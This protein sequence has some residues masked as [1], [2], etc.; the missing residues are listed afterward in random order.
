MSHLCLHF[1]HFCWVLDELRHCPFHRLVDCV[2]ACREHLVAMV[3]AAAA[4]VGHGEQ[5]VHEVT[6]LVV[7]VVP[8]ALLVVT[9]HHLENL[10]ELGRRPLRPRVEPRRPVHPPEPREHVA[11]CDRPQQVGELPHRLAD[12]RRLDAAELL[13]E[14]RPRHDGVGQ[15]DDELSQVDDASASAARRADPVHERRDLLLPEGAERVDPP[16]AEE[17]HDGDAAEAA[18][19]L[20][21]GAERDVPAAVQRAPRRVLLRPAA[22]HVVLVPE[23]GLRHGRRGD[24]ERAHGAEPE[25]EQRAVPPRELAQRPVVPPAAELVEVANDR[26]RRRRRDRRTTTATVRAARS[27]VAPNRDDQARRQEEKAHEQA[28]V[29][30]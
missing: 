28:G 2:R 14:R 1:R 30:L 7:V 12:L 24:D 29:E 9:E 20:A 15:A 5:V 21:V 4:T 6:G 26:Q 10:V 3:V 27:Q 17:V 13:P 11:H 22:E 8:A 19:P 25:L 18:P 23:H 16:R